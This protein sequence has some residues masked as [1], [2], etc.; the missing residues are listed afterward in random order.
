MY[1]MDREMMNEYL[2]SNANKIDFSFTN[3][4]IK[5]TFPINEL[6]NI[7]RIFK[8]C[9]KDFIIRLKFFI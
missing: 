2:K 9:L 8:M 3:K 1:L 4:F 7:L 5:S 6:L